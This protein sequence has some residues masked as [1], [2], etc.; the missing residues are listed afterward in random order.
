MALHLDRVAVAGQDTEN[1]Y[2]EGPFAPTMEELTLPGLELLE[3]RS[4]TT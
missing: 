2:L 4:P 1:P 3:A